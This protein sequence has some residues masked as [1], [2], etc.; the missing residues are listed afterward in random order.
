M[1]V[2]VL[3][4][5]CQEGTDPNDKIAALVFRPPGRQKGDTAMKRI[6]GIWYYQGKAYKS[7]REAL[8][9]AWPW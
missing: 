4:Y 1:H 6:H 3:L 9:A 5:H 7:F 2:N 8:T